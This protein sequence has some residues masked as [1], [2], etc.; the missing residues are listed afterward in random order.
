MHVTTTMTDWLNRLQLIDQGIHGDGSPGGGDPKN[1]EPDESGSAKSAKRP[2]T[3]TSSR[4][5]HESIIV[6]YQRFW[7]DYDLRD[8]TYTPA[9]LQQAEL[10]VNHGP[11]LQYRLQWPGGTPQPNTTHEPMVGGDVKMFAHESSLSTKGG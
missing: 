4:A 9:E 11:V 8:G 2:S 10:L 5:G 7:F 3:D 6:A 1:L